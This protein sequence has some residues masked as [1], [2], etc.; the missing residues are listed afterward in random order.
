MNADSQTE[1]PRERQCVEIRREEEM[2]NELK[3]TSELNE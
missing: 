2:K 3:G 1:R